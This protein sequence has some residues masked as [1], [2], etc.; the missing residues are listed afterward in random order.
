MTAHKRAPELVKMYSTALCSTLPPPAASWGQ[1]ATE[2]CLPYMITVRTEDIA[3]QTAQQIRKENIVPGSRWACHLASQIS[4]RYITLW[5]NARPAQQV[6]QDPIDFVDRDSGWMIALPTITYKCK[7]HQIRFVV[8][9]LWR[10]P[11]LH[12]EKLLCTPRPET[13]Y[14]EMKWPAP[15]DVLFDYCMGE[16]RPSDTALIGLTS[17]CG[18]RILKIPFDRNSSQDVLQKSGPD[19]HLLYTGPHFGF[20]ELQ[21]DDSRRTSFSNLTIEKEMGVLC[22]EDGTMYKIEYHVTGPIPIEQQKLSI[23]RVLNYDVD[24]QEIG[25]DLDLE[26]CWTMQGRAFMRGIDLTIMR[27]QLEADQNDRDLSPDIDVVADEVDMIQTHVSLPDSPLDD[28]GYDSTA[29]KENIMP[30]VLEQVLVHFQGATEQEDDNPA[31]DEHFATPV[32]DLDDEMDSLSE[33]SECSTPPPPPQVY[34]VST[35]VSDEGKT[36]LSIRFKDEAEVASTII[37]RPEEPVNAL[38]GR[39]GS[40]SE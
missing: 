31:V 16:Y 1:M 27:K 35:T 32:P 22:S 3:I 14:P 19:R 26:K 29:D 12:S 11:S 40:N 8:E 10:I 36:R 34:R 2:R 30:D 28:E 4:K 37:Y 33:G 38:L 7:Q 21:S 25:K 39:R 18:F 23:Q 9:C 15:F 6:I 20:L 24:S 5:Y 17:G 13:Y